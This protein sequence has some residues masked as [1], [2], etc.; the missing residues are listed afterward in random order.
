MNLGCQE[1]RTRD[2]ESPVQIKLASEERE[3]YGDVCTPYTV[4]TRRKGTD[5]IATFL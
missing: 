5:E 3:M 4:L 2:R 1:R